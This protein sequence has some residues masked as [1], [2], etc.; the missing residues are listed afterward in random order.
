MDLLAS[1]LN[2]LADLY[3]F[4]SSIF[5]FTFGLTYLVINFD[6]ETF[7]ADFDLGRLS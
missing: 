6:R 1:Q 4:I 5:F 7:S 3:L 2:L